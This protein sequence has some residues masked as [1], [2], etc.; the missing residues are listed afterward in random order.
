MDARF[1]P[2]KPQLFVSSQRTIR[3]YDLAQ[4]QLVKKLLPGARM[5]SGIDLHPRGDHLLASSYDKRVLWHDLDLAATPYKTLRYHEK[6]VRSIKFHKG[7]MPLFASASD[8]GTI[9]VFHSTVYDDYMTNPLLVPLKKLT[10]HK[11]VSS[12]GV[13]DLV[14]HPKEAWL[15][16]AG[17]DGTARLWTT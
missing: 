13:L 9:H 2:F 15:F 7:K 14:W 12:I 4:Q 17:A 11:I 10:G 3:I 16:S 6:A 8:D 1:H 5:L